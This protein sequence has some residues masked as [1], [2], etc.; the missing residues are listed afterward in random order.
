MTVLQGCSSKPS[1]NPE[2][3]GVWRRLATWNELMDN[4]K[5]WLIGSSFAYI[6]P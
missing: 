1:Q 6:S 5:K 2:P 3:Q 4:I